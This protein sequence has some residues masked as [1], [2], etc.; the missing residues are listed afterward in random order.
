MEFTYKEP[1]GMEINVQFNSIGEMAQYISDYFNI[2]SGTFRDRY[3]LQKVDAKY[4]GT[5]S[6]AIYYAII[7]RFYEDDYTRYTRSTFI[8]TSVTIAPTKL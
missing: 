3:G 7:K 4:T 1:V 8:K 6:E 2:P 5:V